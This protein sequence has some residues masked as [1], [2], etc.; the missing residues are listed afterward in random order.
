MVPLS[1]EEALHPQEEDH[2]T[3]SNLHT[4]DR[5]YLRN[6]FSS[7]IA[8]IQGAFVVADRRIAW[9][10]EGTYAHGPDVAVIF[11]V[12]ERKLWS[13][14]NVVE[15]G[16]RPALII[17][18][19]SWSTRENDVEKK[20]VEYAE[21]G[22]A[23][24]VIVDADESNGTRTISFIHYQLPDGAS[25]YEELPISANGR[26]WLPEVKLWLGEEQGLVACYDPRGRK[27]PN[28]VELDR[29]VMELDA[30]SEAAEARAEA[31]EQAITTEVEARMADIQARK[32]AE[33]LAAEKVALVAQLQAEIERLRGG[34]SAEPPVVQS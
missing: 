25:E 4:R 18:V 2:Y 7:R 11:N 22:V 32:A 33:R 15:E 8:P 17:E 16:T 10:A 27:I 9:D 19:T 1:L 34:N 3:V 26:V 14:F 30:R 29:A 28:Y 13:T 20:V 31:A 12:S 24:Y 23:R 21:A 6:V 5:N